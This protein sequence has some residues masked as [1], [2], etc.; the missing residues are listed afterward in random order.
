MGV[1]WGWLRFSRYVV[2]LYI[3]DMYHQMFYLCL[4]GPYMILPYIYVCLDVVES[5]VGIV[6]V[7][8]ILLVR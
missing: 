6:D 3:G 8:V 7:L 1:F 5:R 4:Y 2:R